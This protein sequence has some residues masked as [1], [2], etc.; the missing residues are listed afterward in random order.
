M[1][2]KIR[3]LAPSIMVIALAGFI[4]TIFFSWGMNVTGGHQNSRNVGRIADEKIPLATFDKQVQLERDKRVQSTEGSL[5]D[6]ESAMI[7]LQVWES[8]VNQKIN[9]MAFERLHLKANADEVYRYLKNNPP[10]QI[11]NHPAFQTDSVFDST[12]YIQFL[13]DPRSLA[14]SGIQ[15][16]EAHV[17]TMLL[18]MQKLEYLVEAA[19]FVSKSEVARRYRARHEQ[20]VFEYLRVPTANFAI[21][22]SEITPDM[23]EKYYKTHP[24]SFQKGERVSLYYTQ[25][26]K[27]ATPEDMQRYKEELLQ[28]KNDIVQGPRTFAEA[29]KIQSDDDHS[30]QR[31]G[32]LGW[33]SRGSL[34]PSFEKVAFSLKPGEISRPIRTRYGYHLIKL[35]DKKV[36]DSTAQVKVRHIL[37]RSY[38]STETLDRLEATAD[39]LIKK[40]TE[41]SVSSLDASRDSAIHIDSTEYLTRKELQTR[42]NYLQG[43]GQFAFN[44]KEGTVVAT[45][46]EN[47]AA[48]YIFKIRERRGKGR[49]KL[50]TV[51]SKIREMLTDSLQ[52]KKAQSFLADNITTGSTAS[53]QEQFSHLAHIQ[54]EKTDTVT[55]LSYIKG[56]GPRSKVAAAAFGCKA[57]SISSPVFFSDAYYVVR[58]L[59][60]SHVA[61]I[62]WD[63][64]EIPLIKEK[65][66]QQAKKNIY[67]QWYHAQKKRI[68]IEN[69]VRN[70]YM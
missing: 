23:V 24:D 18:P 69:N 56:I 50:E 65:L 47:E 61:Q 2:S 11:K 7:P 4:A 5:S 64:G 32:L 35:E 34:L 1:I 55:R 48:M 59:W 51:R 6:R 60:H 52:K 16:L 38:P 27:K 15:Q 62:P 22:S 63:S 3:V 9:S 43:L 58:P 37:R 45:P 13:N 66:R 54:A 20:T 53:L 42:F 14:Q 57:E 26:E 46:Y 49:M 41:T 21:D 29:A 39:S 25:I 28:L 30:A 10:A 36:T 17:A 44:E 40:M 8:V 31:G 19:V 67:M 68:N 70:Y 33:V 12:K